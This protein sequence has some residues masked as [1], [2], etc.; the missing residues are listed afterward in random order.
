MLVIKPG[1]GACLIIIFG[2][3]LG[4]LRFIGMSF[5]CKSSQVCLHF[6]VYL[7]AVMMVEVGAQRRGISILGSDGMVGINSLF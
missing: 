6:T 4:I 2:P 1:S 3:N 7:S 5:Y